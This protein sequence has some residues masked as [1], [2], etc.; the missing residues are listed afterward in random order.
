MRVRE[1]EKTHEQKDP[2]NI[3]DYHNSLCHEIKCPMQK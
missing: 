2:L 1:A 3:G